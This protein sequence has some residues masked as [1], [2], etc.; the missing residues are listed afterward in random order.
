ME[1]PQ[2]EMSEPL[3]EVASQCSTP[4]T[5][6]KRVALAGVDVNRNPEDKPPEKPK[7]KKISKND[8][9]QQPTSQMQKRSKDKTQSGDK[10]QPTGV[11]LDIVEFDIK[12]P[13]TCLDEI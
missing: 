1:I 6:R 5:T 10:S 9:T 12:G 7:Q 3:K 13:L 8:E 2:R 11:I 4:K